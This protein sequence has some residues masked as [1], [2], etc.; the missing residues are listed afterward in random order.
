MIELI[1]CFVR[2]YFRRINIISFASIYDQ[3]FFLLFPKS[4]Y[5]EENVINY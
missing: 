4:N 2:N 5:G 3:S 1:N